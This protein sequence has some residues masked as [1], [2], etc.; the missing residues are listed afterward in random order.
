M[1][2]SWSVLLKD[3]CVDFKT[4]VDVIGD[5]EWNV[6]KFLCHVTA[7]AAKLKAQTRP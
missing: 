7:A 2:E 3:E 5:L 6:F 4:D 1:N